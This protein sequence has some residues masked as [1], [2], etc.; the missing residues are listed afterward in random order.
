MATIHNGH[1]KRLKDRFSAEGLSHFDDIHI[2]E[3][4]LFYAVPQKDTT[5]IAHALLNRFGSLSAVLDARTEDLIA[6]NGIGES[7]AVLLRMMPQLMGR[8]L[9][10]KQSFDKILTTTTQCGQYLLPRF[11]SARDELV[12]LLMLDG[13]C[14]VLDCRLIHTGSVNTAGVS[15]RKIVEAALSVNATSVILAH[16]HT[17]GIALPSAADKATTKKL[18][19]ALAAVDILLAD[20]IVVAGDDFVSLAD[21][22]FFVALQKQDAES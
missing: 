20:H 5:P 17:S 16:N 9:Q 19:E 12:Y 2:L 22:G 21:D 15:I 18:Y 4:L 8:Y 13:K 7:A 1:R 14:M 10:D 3:L 11:L 6:V